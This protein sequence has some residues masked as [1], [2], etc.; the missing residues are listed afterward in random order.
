M[1]I[2]IRYT[3]L[4]VIDSVINKCTYVREMLLHM[5]RAKMFI[6]PPFILIKIAGAICL[7]DG[8]LVG[9][10]FPCSTSTSM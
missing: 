5:L 6:Y 4:Y 1:A 8:W 10:R 7:L 3:T 2:I 9:R